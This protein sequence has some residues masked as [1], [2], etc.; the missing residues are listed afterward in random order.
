MS[1]FISE[2]VFT[3]ILPFFIYFLHY[4]RASADTNTDDSAATPV[5]TNAPEPTDAPVDGG[6]VLA[7]T[8]APVNTE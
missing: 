3:N 4:D 6:D 1:N 8:A 2:A 7:T 5:V